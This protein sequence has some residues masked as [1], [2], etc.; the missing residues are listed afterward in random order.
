MERICKVC[1]KEWYCDTSKGCK[2]WEKKN[3]KCINCLFLDERGRKK[4]KG[5][6]CFPSPK[7]W[8]I[9]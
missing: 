6:V 5:S 8:R 2:R 4:A 1:G 7:E 9:A 3:C